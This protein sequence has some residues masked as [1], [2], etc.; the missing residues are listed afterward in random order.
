MHIT[1]VNYAG[2]R[3]N[4]RV[5]TPWLDLNII[6]EVIAKDDYKIRQLRDCLGNSVK[7][8]LDIGGHIGT[9]GVF[10]KSL[11]PEAML[12]AL[13]PDP[14]N[15]RLYI[16]NLEI[17]GLLDGKC[18]VLNAAIGYD[19]KC[20]FLLHSPF[21]T[22]GAVMRTEKEAAQY[23]AEDYRFY[24][25][26]T[27]PD[28]KVW[29]IEEICKMH[30][31]TVIDL[32]KFDCEGGEIDVFKNITKEAA[33]RFRYIVGEYHIWDEKSRYLKADLFDCIRFWREVKKKFSHLNFE[34]KDN[35]LGLFQAWPTYV[36]NP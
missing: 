30:K 9:F 15:Y 12:I 13:E 2:F 26:V 4:I 31:I 24:N 6:T 19:P 23:L 33:A 11:W 16:K 3:W 32:A 1:Q 10:A 18:K 17:N 27:D 25:S 22:G 35:R 8:I 29:T 21:S 28:V 14:D 36:S 5:P 7:T 20:K 34:Y